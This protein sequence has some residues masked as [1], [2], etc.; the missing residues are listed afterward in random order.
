MKSLWNAWRERRAPKNN[1]T[2]IEQI[3]TEL[4]AELDARLM[5]FE[6]DPHMPRMAELRDLIIKYRDEQDPNIRL[7]RLA[8]HDVDPYSMVYRERNGTVYFAELP[9]GSRTIAP[10]DLIRW[11]LRGDWEFDS[12]NKIVVNKNGT[13]FLHEDM[14]PTNTRLLVHYAA[15]VCDPHRFADPGNRLDIAAQLITNMTDLEVGAAELVGKYS[16]IATRDELTNSWTITFSDDPE[17]AKQL[18]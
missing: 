7:L 11:H 6:I 16:A 18:T 17:T 13:F 14:I 3:A 5:V 9:F 1:P 10:W 2:E 12:I 15:G 4:L 8:V